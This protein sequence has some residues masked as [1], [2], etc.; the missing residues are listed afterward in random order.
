MFWSSP[1][2]QPR[3]ARPALLAVAAV[4]LFLYSYRSAPYLETYYAAAVRSM[5]SNWHNFFFGAFDPAATITLDKLPG[6][7]W[8][9]AAFVRVFGV[10]PWAIVLPQILEGVL[11]ILVLFRVVR[12]LLGARVAIVA[13]LVLAVSPANVALDRGNIS[14]TLMVLC[15]LLA[16]DAAVSVVLTNN[17]RWMIAS[18][19][20]VGVAF[21]AKMLEAWLVLPAVWILV[22]T[23]SACSWRRVAAS[24]GAISVVAVLVSLSWMSV[25]SLVPTHSRPYVDGSANNSEFHQVFVYNGVNRVGALS[26]NEVLDQTLGFH[27]K[28]PP[29]PSIARLFQGS[30]GRDGGWL[31]PAAIL[32]VLAGLLVTARRARG[33]P[34][35]CSFAFWGVWLVVLGVSFSTGSSLNSYYLAALSP[36]V[37]GI[38]AT[39]AL[40]VWSRRDGLVARLI[41]LVIV[42]IT[43]VYG[44]L[45][46]PP[47]GEGVGP[48]IIPLAIA[49]AAAVAV[50]LGWRSL[51]ANVRAD[52]FVGTGILCA[53]LVLP[54]V[55][56]LTFVANGLGTLDTPFESGVM[57]QALRTFFGTA[58]TRAVLPDL[59]VAQNGAPDL[60]ATQSSALAAPFIFETGFEVLPIGGYTGV[61]PSPTLKRLKTLIN[62]GTFHLVLA[63]PHPHDAR[64]VWIDQHCN[65]LPSPARQQPAALSLLIYYCRPGD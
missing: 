1:Q 48:W 28:S 34:W 62:K 38:V 2:D 23:L 32:I 6:A 26:P 33:D 47:T 20:W 60:M 31:L 58:A 52:A 4:A 19:V 10:H 30:L 11:S 56:S 9:Q 17:K 13:A 12:R 22:I 43:V 25:V 50:S 55:A 35:R 45:L 51:V 3:W 27:L 54:T 21:Q 53:I 61:T 16:L 5:S 46:L 18:G 40:F 63:G 15:L 36:A 44:V 37:A 24:V 8:V 57:A 49:I 42:A 64:F 7:F 39:G 41:V 59:E 14:D 29:A 65:E